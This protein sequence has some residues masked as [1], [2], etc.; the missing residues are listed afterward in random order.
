MKRAIILGIILG[1]IWFISSCGELQSP[2]AK[3]AY[4]ISSASM[5]QQANEAVANGAN[6]N[7]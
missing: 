6:F 3:I 2:D 1:S 7:Q 4:A 5:F